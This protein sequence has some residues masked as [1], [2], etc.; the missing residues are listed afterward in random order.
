MGVLVSPEHLLEIIVP[1][2]QAVV[3]HIYLQIKYTVI[4]VCQIFIFRGVYAFAREVFLLVASVWNS[5]D[6]LLQI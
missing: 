3:I 1:I 6:V 4:R 2:F 5:M